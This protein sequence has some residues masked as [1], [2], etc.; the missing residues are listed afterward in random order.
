[1]VPTFGVIGEDLRANIT[2]I[3]YALRDYGFRASEDVYTKQNRGAALPTSIE[4]INE[5]DTTAAR[6][7]DEIIAITHQVED[8]VTADNLAIETF[9]EEVRLDKLS[10]E[11]VINEL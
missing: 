10:I 2:E 9:R 11:A 8:K 6:L 7:R 5:M 4:S 1:M 3:I